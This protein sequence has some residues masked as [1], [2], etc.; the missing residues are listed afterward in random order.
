M[1]VPAS[2]RR[3]SA[4]GIGL[5]RVVDGKIVEFWVSPDRVTIMPQIGALPDPG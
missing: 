5:M 1:G 3:V 2:G 4:T